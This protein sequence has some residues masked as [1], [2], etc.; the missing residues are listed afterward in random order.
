MEKGASVESRFL[1]GLAE[2]ESGGDRERGYEEEFHHS[3]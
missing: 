1:N 3:S 2:C